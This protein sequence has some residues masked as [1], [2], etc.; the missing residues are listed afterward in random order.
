MHKLA[1]S[2]HDMTRNIQINLE[3]EYKFTKLNRKNMV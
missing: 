1:T 2:T 3:K